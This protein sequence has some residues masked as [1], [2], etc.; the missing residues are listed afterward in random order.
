M[1]YEGLDEAYIANVEGWTQS[2]TCPACLRT[3][4]IAMGVKHMSD[5]PAD[6]APR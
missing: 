6:P 4:L 5:T 3:A 2:Q 1:S